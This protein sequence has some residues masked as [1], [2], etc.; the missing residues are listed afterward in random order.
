[1]A[2]SPVEENIVTQFI[3]GFTVILAMMGGGG[4]VGGFLDMTSVPYGGVLGTALGALL[5]F[6]GFS[7]LYRRYVASYDEQVK[8][9]ENPLS[10]QV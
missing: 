7:I 3:L 6:V 5:V 9:D 1:M 10:E 2:N 8:P 4:A